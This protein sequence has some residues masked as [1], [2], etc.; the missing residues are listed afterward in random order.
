MR[1][2]VLFKRPHIAKLYLENGQIII[3]KNHDVK[4]VLH[5]AEWGDT[6]RLIQTHKGIKFI[7]DSELV[8]YNSI[9]KEM[10]IY[11][12]SKQCE[13]WHQPNVS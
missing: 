2:V 1:A 11:K 3:L 7:P 5:C 12:G 8:V 10:I 9:G 4:N 6:G 13:N